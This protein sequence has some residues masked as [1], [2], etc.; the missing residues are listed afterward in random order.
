MPEG[1]LAP[2]ARGLVADWAGQS[3]VLVP[4]GCRVAAPGLLGHL[5][6]ISD[7]GVICYKNVCK[8]DIN[9]AG[10]DVQT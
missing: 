6:S 10:L 2:L 4:W 8:R 7:L 9:P 1:G 3:G 5:P